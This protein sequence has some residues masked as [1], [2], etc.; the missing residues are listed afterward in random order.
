MN[1]ECCR[2]KIDL[3]KLV[4]LGKD[5][6]MSLRDLVYYCAPSNLNS[7]APPKLMDHGL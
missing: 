6:S 2:D 5:L 4:R 3:N 7:S 1:C